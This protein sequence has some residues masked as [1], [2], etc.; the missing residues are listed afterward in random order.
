MGGALVATPLG[1]NLKGVYMLAFIF[2]NV[3]S[4]KTIYQSNP[5]DW[6]S[7][8]K[9]IILLVVAIIGA[10]A[11][12]VGLKTWRKQLKGNTE[13]ELSR[14][15]LKAVFHARDQIK[16][17][18]NPF[19]DGGEI[20]EAIKQ[21]GIEI[22]PKDLRHSVKYSRA[23][24]SMRWRYLSEVLSELKIELLEAEVIWG[25]DINK[26][27]KEFYNCVSE[28]NFAIYQHLNS[29]DGLFDL[30]KEERRQNSLILNDTSDDPL[31][32]EFSGKVIKSVE[33]IEEFVRPKLKI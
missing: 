29:Q 12:I 21:S 7:I 9:D 6:F 24:Y 3:N 27:F 19:M 16:Y 32:N 15:L 25:K 23:V 30:S 5:I 20:S 1:G 13:Y 14:R 22:E 18:R 11:A 28:L 31:K 33:A 26:I 2:Q 8:I 4:V 10:F 17:I